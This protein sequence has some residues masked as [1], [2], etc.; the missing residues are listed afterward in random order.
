MAKELSYF[1]KD[2]FNKNEPLQ[3]DTLLN[4]ILFDENTN[5]AQLS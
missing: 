5:I 4:F 2:P 3:I 1:S